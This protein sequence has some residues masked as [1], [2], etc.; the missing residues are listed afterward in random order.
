MNQ[1]DY[2][3]KGQPAWPGLL[4][5]VGP[6]EGLGVRAKLVGRARKAR[7]AEQPIGSSRAF[8]ARLACL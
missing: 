1:T 7:C 3:R 6:R 4:L 8:R 5:H 2:P